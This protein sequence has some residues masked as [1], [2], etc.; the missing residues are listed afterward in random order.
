MHHEINTVDFIKMR[1]AMIF[2]FSFLRASFSDCWRTDAW[3][4]TNYS[5]LITEYVVIIVR[6]QVYL[7]YVTCQLTD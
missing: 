7:P 1:A 6:V 4:A 5:V 2:F 3:N